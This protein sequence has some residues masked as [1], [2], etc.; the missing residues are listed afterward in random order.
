MS[1]KLVAPGKRKNNKFYLAL[2]KINGRYYEISTRTRDKVAAQRI[3]ADAEARIRA[4]GQATNRLTFGEAVDRY[5]ARFDPGTDDLRRLNALKATIGQRPVDEIRQDDLTEAANKLCPGYQNSSKNRNIIVPAAA[6]LHYAAENEWCPYRRFAKYREPKPVTRS[7]KEADAAKLLKAASG[8]PRLLLLWLFF[9]GNRISEALSVE[10]KYLDL[11][12]GV[13]KVWIGKTQQWREFVLDARV[14]AELK[15]QGMDEGKVFP[16]ANRWAAYKALAPTIRESRVRFT[17]HMARHSLGTW[18]AS[19]GASQRLIQEALG[20][21]DMKSSARYQA[22][23]V[24]AVRENLAR[25]GKKV[26]VR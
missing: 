21:A 13:G 26:G 12:R 22:A 17:P 6:V 16:W 9:Q 8:K 18:L 4:S 5:I 19:A 1:L 3:K 23:E 14:V 10:G 2:G 11:K 15:T 20:H 24:K 7:L 25:V